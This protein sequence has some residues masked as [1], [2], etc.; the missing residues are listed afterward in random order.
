M[1]NKY[2]EGFICKNKRGVEITL[3]KR[4][5][6]TLWKAKVNS[7]SDEFVVNQSQIT[8]SGFKTPVCRTVYNIGY[9][10]G[11]EYFCRNSEGLISKEYVVWAN[12][13]K[14]CY[15]KYT[16]DKS[17]GLYD[18]I[19][20]CESWHNYQN[21]AKWFNN[22]IKIFEDNNITPKL[23]KDLLGGKEYSPENCVILPNVINCSIS[24]SRKTSKICH[25]VTIVNSKFVAS[26]MED[27]VPIWLGTFSNLQDAFKAYI[28]SKEDRIRNLAK[29]YE[30]VLEDRAY[31][32]LINWKHSGEHLCQKQ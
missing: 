21:F 16:G 8:D 7:T 31:N 20:V 3:L 11:G 5:S 10:G 13:L 12:M 14:R 9:I 22:K 26:I 29:Q 25:G 4:L 30:Y 2:T 17:N 19:T 15:T 24:E 6:K 32:A 28:D 23:D 27:G 18:D 1:R